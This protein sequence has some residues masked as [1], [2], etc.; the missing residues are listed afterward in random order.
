[1]GVIER[2]TEANE[3]S[4]LERTERVGASPGDT[5]DSRDGKDEVRHADTSQ[6]TPEKFSHYREDE[7][8]NPPS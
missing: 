3:R 2:L 4:R 8:A 7:H 1:M 5:R 6:A